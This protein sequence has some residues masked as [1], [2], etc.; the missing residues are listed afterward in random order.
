MSAGELADR[1]DR[2]LRRI[3]RLSTPSDGRVTV[4]QCPDCSA[5]LAVP[6]GMRDG[7]CPECGERLDLDMLVAGRLGEAGQ[8]VM[9]CSRAGLRTTRK[10]VS[11]WLT[12]GRLSKAR[13][14]GRGMWE[15]NQAE[16]VDTRL[17]QEGE[18]M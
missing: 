1:L 6:Q 4:V 10:Q 12:R 18:S 17:A 9:T 11:N 5:S 8:A 3:D 7:W 16:L 15:F 14:I 13:R 2:M